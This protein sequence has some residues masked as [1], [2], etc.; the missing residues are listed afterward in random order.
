LL[1]FDV[2]AIRMRIYDQ[3]STAINIT[4]I[5]LYTMYFHSTEGATTLLPDDAAALSPTSFFEAAL[6][7]F[8]LS[9]HIL[10]IVIAISSCNT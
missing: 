10:F 9:E 8:A 7:E 6:A 3:F 5:G 4:E 1:N 2:D